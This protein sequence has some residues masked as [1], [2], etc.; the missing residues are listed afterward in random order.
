MSKLFG[1]YLVDK[2][3]INEEQLLDALISQ[4]EE[5]SSVVKVVRDLDL[6][7]KADILKILKQQVKDQT[8]FLETAVKLSYWDSE[9]NKKLFDFMSTQ[10]T[11]L[12]EILVGKKYLDIAKLTSA[13]DDFFGEKLKEPEVSTTEKSEDSKNTTGDEVYSEVFEH[14][15]PQFFEKLNQAIS[16]V[17]DGRISNPQIW[18]EISDEL[19]KIQSAAKLYDFPEMAEFV[20]KSEN[21]I[22]ELLSRKVDA[23]YEDIIKKMHSAFADSKKVLEKALDEQKNQTLKSNFFSSESNS[24]IVKS[25]YD[26]YSLIEFDIS[27]IEKEKGA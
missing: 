15:G 27:H 21:I 10:R 26:W 18:K 19:H 4:I 23:L 2:G 8:S 3:L 20:E 12:G 14:L 5:Q 11:P 13:L 16:S 24:K 9:K 6:I 1:E 22:R 7:K 25:I 17:A